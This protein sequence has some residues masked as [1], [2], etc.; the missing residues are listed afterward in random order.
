[1]DK[2]LVLTDNEYLYDEFR[3]IIENKHFIQ[4]KFDFRFSPKNRSF[5][6]K[7]KDSAQFNSI[8]VSESL[9]EIIKEY[10]LVVSLHCKQIFPSELVTTVRCI[11]IHPGFNP[12]NRGFFPQV[13][14]I[15]NKKK[16]GVTIHE[17]DAEL[18]H[19]P[20]IVREEISVESWETSGDVYRK[21]LGAE[22]RLIRENLEDIINGTYEL[23]YPEQEGN[24]NYFRDFKKLCQIDLTEVA[25]YNEVI[26]R[27]R[28]LT[29][30]DYKNAYFYDKNGTK[31]FI[32]ILLEPSSGDD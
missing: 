14:S 5:L 13:F 30:D 7:Y 26:D 22:I 11:N 28:A 3:K 10:K 4:Y 29:H 12:Y 32:K 8:S 21:I 31:V 20:I 24:I 23:T 27:L 1:M 15:I 17:I 25:S 6:E 2:V 16:V 19:G 18:D 9:E